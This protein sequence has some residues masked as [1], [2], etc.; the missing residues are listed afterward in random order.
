M[1]SGILA[2]MENKFGKLTTKNLEEARQANPAELY[3]TNLI[4]PPPEANS[5]SILF[6]SLSKSYNKLNKIYEEFNKVYIPVPSSN[7]GKKAKYDKLQTLQ[8]DFDNEYKR[9]RESLTYSG[10]D[11]G[12]RNLITDITKLR[13]ELLLRT[14]SITRH[15]IGL[16]YTMGNAYKQFIKKYDTL[17][18]LIDTNPNPN[19][20]VEPIKTYYEM[21]IEPIKRTFESEFNSLDPKDVS[22]DV[23]RSVQ[24]KKA[25]INRR[26]RELFD[27]IALI[28]SAPASVSA[29]VP[30]PVPASPPAPP[31]VPL[32]RRTRTI[33]MNP[34]ANNALKPNAQPPS[35][36]RRTVLGSTRKNKN[37]AIRI[38][39]APAV[40]I[41]LLGTLEEKYNIVAK[42]NSSTRERIRALNSTMKEQHAKYIQTMPD[43][44]VYKIVDINTSNDTAKVLPL[45][46]VTKMWGPVEQLTKE[47]IN[48]SRI[49]DCNSQAGGRRTRRHRRQR[50]HRKTRKA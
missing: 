13:G 15:D 44:I 45:D 16:T 36:N 9:I 42:P 20:N 43:K 23:Y 27:K 19:T 5:N 38:T 32:S 10:N 8:T 46:R 50:K 34:F 28:Q 31:Q 6:D 48:S 12:V 4:S 22:P 17:K 3:E 49:V 21:N 24:E 33:P 1:S 40:N 2:E 18:E 37:T 14:R 11:K 41:D 29:A 26:V 35:T 39:N 47:Q 30:D 25:D 7:S